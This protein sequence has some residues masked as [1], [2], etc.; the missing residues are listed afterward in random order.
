MKISDV[1][2]DIGISEDI[3]VVSYA[4]GEDGRYV[5]VGS[6]GW[7]PINVANGLAWEQI[8]ETIQATVAEID[9]GKQSPLAFYMVLNQMDVSLLSHYTGFFKWQVRRHLKPR[10]FARL[11][12]VIKEKYADLFKISISE[13]EHVPALPIGEKS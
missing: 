8:A 4:T 6:R 9:R 10:I 12:P 11:K 3:Q 2:Q 13:L 1:P 7:E 5:K